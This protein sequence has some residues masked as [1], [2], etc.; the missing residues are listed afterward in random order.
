MKPSTARDVL[1]AAG[2]GE[3]LY[4][5][6][7]KKLTPR[8]SF[9]ADTDDKAIIDILENDPEQAI[10]MVGA[11]LAQ[12][13][14]SAQGLGATDRQMQY[15]MTVGY[16]R[17]DQG[18]QDLINNSNNANDVVKSLN[19]ESSFAASRRYWSYVGTVYDDYYDQL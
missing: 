1:G 16:N 3:I 15:I 5:D 17:W 18:I 14:T 19:T 8:V 7:D 9:F 13:Q 6:T 12:I 2:R 10:E 4:G 11:R